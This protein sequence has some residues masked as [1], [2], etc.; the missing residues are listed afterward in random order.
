MTSI[1]ESSSYVM[2]PTSVI[3][4]GLGSIHVIGPICNRSIC[5]QWVHH[6]AGSSIC[7]GSHLYVIGPVYT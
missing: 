3:G 2:G 7:K 1:S 5:V 4:G 6:Y